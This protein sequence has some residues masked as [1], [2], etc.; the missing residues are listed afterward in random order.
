M[1][2]SKRLY[3]LTGILLV[4]CAVTF[5]VS[6]YEQHQ[7]DIKN[8]DEV[9]LS[10]SSDDV[11]ALSW[12]YDNT[13]LS[14]KKEDKWEYVDDTSFPVSEDKI[15][16]L[17]SVFESFGASFVIENVDDY[18]Q[19]GLDKPACSIHVEAGDDSYD[20]KLGNYSSMDQER[21]V[22]IGDGNVYL[23]STDPVETYS[24]ELKDMI[25]NDITPANIARADSIKFTGS[26]N[27]TITYNDENTTTY[28]EDDV[29]FTSSKKNSIPLDTD[30]VK[31]YFNILETLSLSDYVTYNA[32]D[33]DLARYGLDDPELTATLTYSSEDSEDETSTFEISISRSAEDKAKDDSDEEN[34]SD[35]YVRIG[36]SS[37]IYEISSS[38]YDSLMKVSVDDLRH[39]KLF[40]GDFD[41]ITGIDVSLDGQTY[42]LTV[43][44]EG[45]DATWKYGD[46]SIDTGD[47]STA[48]TSLSV[49][50]FNSGDA[51]G[52]EELSLTL[53]LDND[54][55]SQVQLS[56]YRLDGSSC[57]AQ[58]DGTTVGT[59]ARTDVVDLIEAINAI[60][61]E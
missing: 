36:D 55:V 32:T 51:D 38:L 4:I 30:N 53:Y 14:F 28:S 25:Q 56:F 52:K 23:V 59:V 50:E 29:Y 35:A 54:N 20:I 8:T 22:S 18:S 11:T 58:V 3:V 17:L 49:T 27:Y 48:I 45:D 15:D 1:K 16:E 24:V 42:S 10:L 61:L 43:E 40:W 2:R 31:S 33:E 26:Q 44:G 47:L 21:Y 6:R 7:E 5:G 13:S 46:E 57:L 12:E 37:I 34:T 60:V 19:Y 41:N 9:I 39:Q